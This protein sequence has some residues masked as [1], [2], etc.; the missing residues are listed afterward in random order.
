MTR[1]TPDTNGEAST[2]VERVAIRISELVSDQ[3]SNAF[4]CE[5]VPE[6]VWES[7]TVKICDIAAEEIRHTLTAAKPTLTD[8]GGLKARLAA[9]TVIRNDSEETVMV[10][11]GDGPVAVPCGGKIVVQR[12]PDG[13]EAVA[14]LEALEAENKRLLAKEHKI[15][16]IGWLGTKTC[17]IDIPREEA[18]KRWAAEHDETPDDNMIEEVTTIRGM[19]DAYDIG[20]YFDVGS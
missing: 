17:Y 4:D 1:A 8:I 9:E 16:S 7:L 2:D 3:I 19:F 15:I 5:D 18:I 13:P 12:N 11:F 14:A 6:S 20:E 10:D